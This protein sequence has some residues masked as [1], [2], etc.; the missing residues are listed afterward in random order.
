M[1]KIY[2]HATKPT[3]TLI[4]KLTNNYQPIPF[5]III[6]SLRCTTNCMKINFKI[7]NSNSTD[8]VCIESRRD[9]MSIEKRG[10]PIIESRRDGMSIS[11]YGWVLMKRMIFYKHFVDRINI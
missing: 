8:P 2:T 6:V 4:I 11:T 10:Y 1:N 3:N 7:G 9:G 5:L